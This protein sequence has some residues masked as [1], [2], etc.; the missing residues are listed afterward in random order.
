MPLVRFR[1]IRQED[2]M[3][4][5]SSMLLAGLLSM[6]GGCGRA[7]P[8]VNYV[9]AATVREVMRSIVDPS[10]NALWQSVV[11]RLTAEGEVSNVPTTD[12]AWTELHNRAIALV[13]ATN[14]LLVP[15]RHVARPGEKAD[16]PEEER[17]PQEI[18]T[19]MTQDRAKYLDQ[20]GGFRQ[21]ATTMLAAVEARDVMAIEAAGDNLNTACED[22]HTVYW[23]RK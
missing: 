7:E 1:I 22:C 17:D 4:V 18:E 20:I 19:M 15:G 5:A 6:S 14:L 11:V 23:Y 13:E 21:V 12:E 2:W 10:A 8:T 16:N 9:P 3:R